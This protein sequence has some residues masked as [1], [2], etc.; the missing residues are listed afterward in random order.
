MSRCFLYKIYSSLEYDGE[1]FL[2]ENPH[3]YI[4]KTINLD[5]RFKQ[6]I[7]NMKKGTRFKL[8]DWM[9]SVGEENIKI[10]IIK[11]FNSEKTAYRH[12]KKTLDNLKKENKFK[13]LNTKE[14]GVGMTSV[15]VSRGNVKRYK[16]PNERKKASE[17]S[18]KIWENQQMRK[19]QS[20][21]MKLVTR[22]NPV[23]L[24][25]I[26]KLNLK[27]WGTNGIREVYRG[28]DK[29]TINYG[30]PVICL[31]DY[32]FYYSAS[33]AEKF[34]G[35]TNVSRIC[36]EELNVCFDYK[37]SW[38]EFNRPIVF[39]NGCWDLL[40]KSHIETINYAKKLCGDNGTVIVAANS[41]ESIKRLKGK[42]R[43]I[44]NELDRAYMLSN[45]LGVDFVFIFDEDTPERLI[46]KIK[47][48]IIVKGSEYE[49]KDV[50]GSNISKINFSPMNENYS[51]TKI[52]EKIK[53][54]P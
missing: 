13:I 47:P 29:E 23:Y 35:I 48:D 44:I 53:K 24:E 45:I 12:E 7:A 14:G 22:G 28:Y 4:G 37:F 36:N 31:N 25:N 1:N 26:K 42:D 27:R 3:L 32:R 16:D 43:P 11:E 54:I 8:Y 39:L 51:T 20:E 52:I 10:S 18:K 33:E 38:V 49:G 19:T 46:V 2:V 40:H 34:Y 5:K 17:R 30:K 9:R 15:D 6:H 50:V 21:K 41:D